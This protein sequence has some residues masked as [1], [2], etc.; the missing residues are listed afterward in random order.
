MEE[1]GDARLDRCRVFY[2]DPWPLQ[3]VQRAEFWS[4]IMA[5][6]D[7]WPGH[8][9]LDS[10]NVRAIAKLLDHATLFTPLPLFKNGDLI[11][12]VRHMI[13]ARGPETVRT[14]KVQGHA[15][16]AGV[17]QGGVRPEDK[18]ANADADTAADVGRRHQTEEVMDVRRALVNARSF[19]YPIMLQLHRFMIAVS[20]VSVNHDGRG[21]TA[22]DPVVWDRRGRVKQRK[23]DVRVTV[24]LAALPGPPG[25]LAGP[26]VQVNGGLVSE[27]VAASVCCVSS[28]GLCTGLLTLVIL[29]IMG[30]PTLSS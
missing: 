27:F 6:Q 19:W 14:T 25:F 17:E 12:C 29:A 22:P 1:Y 20:R 28:W 4:T 2:A 3:T 9:E 16:E 23:V 11:A 18:F 8:L 10:L 13:L 24:D 26:R 15:T 21:G 7:F 30:L 5:L